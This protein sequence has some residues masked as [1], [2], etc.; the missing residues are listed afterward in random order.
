MRERLNSERRLLKCVVLA[1]AAVASITVVR[2]ALGAEPG[3]IGVVVL[4]LFSEQQPTKR[5]VYV[6]QRV[7]PASAAAD[8]G[9]MPGDLIVQTDEKPVAGLDT[10]AMMKRLGGDVGT[11]VKLSIVRADGEFKKMTLVR[12]PY[13]PHLNPS[14]DSFSYVIP[15]N[16]EMDPRYSFPLP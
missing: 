16:W 4:Q 2:P 5:G 9:I 11:P 8:A 6:V 3:T 13:S 7:L 12:K 15:G 1:W 14:T 10:T